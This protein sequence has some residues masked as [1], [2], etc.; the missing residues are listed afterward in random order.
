MSSGDIPKLV[1]VLDM[2]VLDGIQFVYG[3]FLK[4]RAQLM[5]KFVMLLHF[6]Q[7]FPG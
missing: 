2:I 3:L 7:F 6:L 1:K 5:E 4:E